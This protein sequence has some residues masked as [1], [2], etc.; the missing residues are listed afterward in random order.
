MRSIYL[1]HSLNLNCNIKD[2]IKKLN[3]RVIGW[4]GPKILNEVEQYLGYIY[5][6]ENMP[7]PLERPKNLSIKGSRSLRSVTTTF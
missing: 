2:Q 5:S 3:D 7:I 6:V 1:Q 4:S